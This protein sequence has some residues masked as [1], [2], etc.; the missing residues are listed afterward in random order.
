[1]PVENSRAKYL[2]LPVTLEVA[3]WEN[4]RSPRTVILE[5]TGALKSPSDFDLIKVTP[6]HPGTLRK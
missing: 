2:E 6:I 4:T 1:M 5:S 3:S